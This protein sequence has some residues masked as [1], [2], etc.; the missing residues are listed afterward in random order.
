MFLSVPQRRRTERSGE[1]AWAAG[2]C[3]RRAAKVSTVDTGVRVGRVDLD[4]YAQGTPRFARF[5]LK[6]LVRA[7]M[8]G[9]L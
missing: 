4:V 3:L 5:T 2:E 7:G 6:R 9:T 8:G 1:V